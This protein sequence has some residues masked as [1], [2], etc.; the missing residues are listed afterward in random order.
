MAKVLIIKWSYLFLVNNVIMMIENILK[1]GV[2][3]PTVSWTYNGRCVHVS[4]K[5]VR[6]QVHM[7]CSIWDRAFA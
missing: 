3:H 6:P 2:G 7:K 1:W 5:S 4:S